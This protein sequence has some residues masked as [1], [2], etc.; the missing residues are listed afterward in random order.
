MFLKEGILSEVFLQRLMTFVLLQPQEAVVTDL[1]WRRELPAVTQHWLQPRNLQPWNV[2]KSCRYFRST[3]GPAVRGVPSVGGRKRGGRKSTDTSASES[4]N[5]TQEY[6]SEKDT[7][8]RD[9]G[10]YRGELERTSRHRI[11]ELSWKAE[12]SGS[13]EC[14]W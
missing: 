3:K 11:H 9:K 12:V 13:R 8:E 10:F 7:R 4:R 14:C 5:Q 1:L 6:R 2:S